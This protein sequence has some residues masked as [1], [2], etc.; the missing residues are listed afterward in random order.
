MNR[1]LCT[2]SIPGLA[3]SAAVLT[4]ALAG[5]TGF[6]LRVSDDGRY[7]ED[8]NGT[9]F[10]FVADTQWPLFGRYSLEEAREI[11]D[12]R[13][14]RGFTAILVQVA[15]AAG[16]LPNRYGHRPFVDRAAL[17]VDEEY[18]AHADRVLDYASSKGLA[19]YA[20]PLWWRQYHRDAT[21]ENLDAYGRWLGQRWKHRTNLIW[22]LGGDL[23]FR[24]SDRPRFRTLARAIREGGAKQIMSWHPYHGIPWSNAGHSS[25][26]FLHDEPWLAFNSVQARAQGGRMT[27]RMLAD[28]NREPAK[29]T[30]LIETWYFWPSLWRRIP[31]H[32]PA[33]RVRQSHYQARIGGGGFGEAYGAY[34]FWDW[35]STGNG[36]RRALD[37][38]PAATQIATH[39][40]RCLEGL[41]WWSLEPDQDAEILVA[42]RGWSWSWGRAVA[43]GNSRHSQ[44]V[45]YVPSHREIEI[46]LRWFHGEV[47]ARWYDPTDGTDSEPTLHAASSVHRFSPP[48]RNRA[49]DEDFVLVLKVRE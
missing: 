11:L 4:S 26:E 34:P 18:F 21:H 46:D 32:R 45:V 10:Y 43:A 42:G 24:E 44:A 16:N 30:I 22:A 8:A 13:A 23:R 40:R 14:A 12:D 33:Y 47:E 39:M 2:L 15:T 31:V 6:P 25:S 27:A 29:P 36:W 5:A 19:V 41:E 1:R 20:A 48:R 38:Q 49:G 3:A 17:E 7:L 28:Y 35:Y 9:P 37:E